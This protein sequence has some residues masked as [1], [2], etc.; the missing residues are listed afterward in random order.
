[1]TDIVEILRAAQVTDKMSMEVRLL[2]NC[3][4]DEIERLQAALDDEC[5]AHRVCVEM[6]DAANAENERL[7]NEIEGLKPLP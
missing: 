5:A 4:A 3:A 7:R 1:M 2:V 6:R